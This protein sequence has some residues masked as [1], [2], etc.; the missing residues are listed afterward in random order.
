MAHIPQPRGF[1]GAAVANGTLCTTG[2]YDGSYDS[3]AVQA[4]D[5]QSGVWRSCERDVASRRRQ[6]LT[7]KVW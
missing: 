5:L 2:G 7:G 1:A 3:A 4:L 6:F